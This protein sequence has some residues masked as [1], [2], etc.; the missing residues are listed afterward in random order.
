[1]RHRRAAVRGGALAFAPRR[2]TPPADVRR[3]QARPE[4][5]LRW[6][7]RGRP[8]GSEGR[9]RL[10]LRPGRAPPAGVRR[11]KASTTEVPVGTGSARPD[12]N[13]ADR[14]A[15]SAVRTSRDGTRTGGTLPGAA[16][17]RSRNRR[18]RHRRGQGRRTSWMAAP[19]PRRGETTE[20]GSAGPYYTGPRGQ[21]PRSRFYPSL[22][23][24]HDA[25][26]CGSPARRRASSMARLRAAKR[27]WAVTVAYLA[28]CRA[29]GRA[30]GT[31]S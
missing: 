12:T 30:A 2:G 6:A 13:Q 23:V 3:Y 14:S 16:L 9:L 18:V 20:Y 21:A 22:P 29:D 5:R 7:R 4:A 28:R 19:A 11:Y 8:G 17:S 24:T 10:S 31:G 27:R 15:A 25:T 1:M 26:G